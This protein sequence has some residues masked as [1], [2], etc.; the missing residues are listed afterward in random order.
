MFSIDNKQVRVYNKN[1]GHLN[2]K[3]PKLTNQ[4]YFEK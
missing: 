3:Y 1:M 4:K 2:A